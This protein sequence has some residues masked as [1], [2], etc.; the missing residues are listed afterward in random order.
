MHIIA[1]SHTNRKFK[2]YLHIDFG[3]GLYVSI[4]FVFTCRLTEFCSCACVLYIV[5]TTFVCIHV[6]LV[7]LGWAD[8]V[9]A[10]C[11]VVIV[12]GC[13]CLAGCVVLVV[14]G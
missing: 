6:I 1:P 5:C 14:L 2:A 8:R 12:L 9:F 11:V 7:V 10:G 13:L 4:I 3:L